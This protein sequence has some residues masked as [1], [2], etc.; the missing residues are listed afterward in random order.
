MTTYE[1][2]E[3]DKHAFFPPIGGSI[4]QPTLEESMTSSEEEACIISFPDVPRTELTDRAYG[5]N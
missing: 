5:I 3:F 2:G 1:I 4:F